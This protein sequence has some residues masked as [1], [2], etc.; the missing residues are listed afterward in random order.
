MKVVVCERSCKSTYLFDESELLPI[1]V[2]VVQLVEH[3]RRMEVPAE[4]VFRVFARDMGFLVSDGDTMLYMETESAP[5]C[6]DGEVRTFEVCYEVIP[7]AKC[8]L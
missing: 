7:D 4:L 3:S 2:L 1:E 6:D 5:P 8:T